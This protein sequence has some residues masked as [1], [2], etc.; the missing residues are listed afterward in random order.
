MPP[1]IIFTDLDGTLLDHYSYDHDAAV[2]AINALRGRNIP[3]ILTSSKTLE[4]MRSLQNRL[5]NR[6]PF[7]FENGGGVAFNQDDVDASFDLETWRG[8][9]VK[10]F[11]VGRSE[12]LSTLDRL[13]SGYRFTGFSEMDQ[14]TI[15]K[16]TGLDSVGARNAAIRDCSEPL[17]WQDDEARLSD[18][19]EAVEQT[20]LRC[21]AGGRFV[22]VMG[23]FDKA[24]TMAWLVELL[25]GVGNGITTMALGDSDND[26]AMLN[27]ADIAVVVKS[28]AHPA[29]VVDGAGTVTYT[30]EYGPA[31]WNQAVLETLN[32]LNLP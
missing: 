6:W 12:I 4:E 29:P 31:A 22:H 16:L 28:P 5:G 13:K 11:G 7:I 2:D 15:V 26:I 25:Y 20:G 1:L 3:W 18:F 17:L 24:T 8:M 19:T 32:Q 14:Q 10:R 30:N 27:A 21:V 23:Q 9:R